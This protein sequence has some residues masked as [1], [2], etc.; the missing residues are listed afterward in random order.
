MLQDKY[1]PIY[2]RIPNHIKPHGS[3]PA[4]HTHPDTPTKIT[5][6]N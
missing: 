3:I 5:H 2:Q 6:P 1:F 4:V